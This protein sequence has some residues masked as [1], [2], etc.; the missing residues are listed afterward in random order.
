MILIICI[1][2]SRKRETKNLRQKICLRFFV[3]DFEEFL[4]GGN[5]NGF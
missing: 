5:E 2:K 3:S 1:Y 4:L